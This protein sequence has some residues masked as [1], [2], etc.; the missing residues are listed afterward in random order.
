[1]SRTTDF[2]FYIDL[3]PQITHGPV[4]WSLPDSE[5]AYRGGMVL[6]VD[7]HDLTG[8]AL[9]DPEAPL[10]TSG[11]RKA[12]KVEKTAAKDRKAIRKACGLPP[13]V[14]SGPESWLQQSDSPPAPA[15]VLESSKTL[16]Q[17]ADEYCASDKVLK[18]FTYTKASMS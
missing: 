11:R 2:D 3:T 18:E 6:E 14:A 4:H 1:M 10:Q 15:V 12:N 7:S 17:W 5:P 8:I 16:R 13:W 9:G